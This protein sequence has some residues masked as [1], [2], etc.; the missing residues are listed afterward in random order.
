[1]ESKLLDSMVG[2]KKLFHNIIFPDF[3]ISHF[4]GSQQ[5]LVADLWDKLDSNFT[6]Y[7]TRLIS[8]SQ[9]RT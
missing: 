7:A 3:T 6:Y 9:M 2:T 8:L 1:M 5:T 4:S